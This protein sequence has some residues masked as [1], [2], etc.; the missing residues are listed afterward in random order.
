MIISE[1]ITENLAKRIGMGALGLGIGGA[2][3]I[4]GFGTKMVTGSKDP[5]K[6]KS[7]KK[8]LQRARVAGKRFAKG[9]FFGLNQ[10]PKPLKGIDREYADSV[11]R[12]A[13]KGLG[14]ITNYGKNL[15]ATGLV[16]YLGQ[17]GDQMRQGIN[18]AGGRRMGPEIGA[19][20]TKERR[21]E[22]IQNIERS[23]V[24]P[25]IGTAKEPGAIQKLALRDVPD[26][27]RRQMTYRAQD[28]ARK[29]RGIE[30][31]K[32]LKNVEARDELEKAERDI[33]FGG[34]VF[35]KKTKEFVTPEVKQTL[36]QRKQELK[37]VRK[38]YKSALRQTD[39]EEGSAIS[40]SGKSYRD[41][42]AQAARRER[43]DKKLGTPGE[44]RLER[45]MRARR[46]D[47]QKG[48]VPYTEKQAARIAAEREAEA[49]SRPSRKVRIKTKS[50]DTFEFDNPEDAAR[51]RR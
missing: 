14:A 24:Q 29:L 4:A 16:Q 2:K 28:K 5:S 50:G 20:G 39:R 34:K 6:Y 49:G 32:Y 10:P 23:V 38:K 33:M 36:K 3:K 22:G 35:D 21:R 42:A 25:L 47:P 19:S 18:V 44:R 7:P 43:E 40:F 48:A 45:Y 13:R 31:R 11:K 1:V 12:T 37:R 8:V 51:F 26:A 15:A 41:Y 17:M 27:F 30:G 9:E 46:L